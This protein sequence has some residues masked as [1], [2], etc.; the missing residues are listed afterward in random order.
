MKL[1]LVATDPQLLID[2]LYG[3][4][5]R[6][7]CAIVKYGT[8]VRDGMYLGRVYLATD[9]ATAEL[10][11][12]FKDHARIM[13]SL[14]DD[15][16]FNKF[17]APSAVK[18]VC[19]IYEDWPEH[20]A[21]VA[22]IHTQAFGRTDEASI[23]AKIIASRTPVISLI[24]ELDREIVGHVLLSPVTVEGRDE[25]RGLGLAPLGVM[26]SHWRR[27]IGEQLVHAGLERA[28]LYGYD[29]VVVLGE[30]RYYA[31]F[32][33]TAASRFG[34]RCEYEAPDSA[35]MAIELH[36]GVLHRAPGLVLYAPALRPA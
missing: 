10:C 6:S 36:G 19:G 8:N 28:R 33:F 22:S 17:R 14:Q 29:F 23:V 21:R 24:A 35:F 32:G 20:A 1:C 13:A 30:P 4:S 11:A 7:D 27:G 12:A 26:P 25:P 9:E 5:L 16:F 31:R 15:A 3:L 34:L 2:T 18:G